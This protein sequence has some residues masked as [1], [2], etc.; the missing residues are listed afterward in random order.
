M[1][2]RVGFI[3]LGAIGRPMAR[4]VVR[5]FG[6]SVWNRTPE[7]ARAFATETGATVAASAPD[8]EHVLHLPR[9][10]GR[11]LFPSHRFG[12]HRAGGLP[13]WAQVL[14]AGAILGAV[15][16]SPSRRKD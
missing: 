8:L 4:H 6:A 11:K 5:T 16:A 13:A 15:L 3:G 2:E 9:P 12:W 7:R 1:G 10:G 14:A